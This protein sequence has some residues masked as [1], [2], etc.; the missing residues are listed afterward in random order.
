MLSGNLFSGTFY[1]H[2]LQIAQSTTILLLSDSYEESASSIT[3]YFFSSI[4]ENIDSHKTALE[5]NFKNISFEIMKHSNP[6]QDTVWF[7]KEIFSEKPVIN[8]E[9]K[10]ERDSLLGGIDELN[11]QEDEI[12]KII[13]MGHEADGLQT[14]AGRNLRNQRDVIGKSAKSTSAAQNNLTK[15]NRKIELIS[16]RNMIYIGSLYGMA[17]VLFLIIICVFIL[18]VKNI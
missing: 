11:R 18:K 14:N 16:M 13:H 12:D 6:I 5:N 8:E 15:A 10:D 2:L 9:E 7:F 17:G 3:L 1:N 4:I